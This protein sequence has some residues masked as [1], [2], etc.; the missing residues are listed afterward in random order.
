MLA[1]DYDDRMHVIGHD[2]VA[3]EG[4][5]IVVIRKCAQVQIG[6]LSVLGELDGSFDDST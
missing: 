4:N 1:L 2:N 5:V 6:D 3:I